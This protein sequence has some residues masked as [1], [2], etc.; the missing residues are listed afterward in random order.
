MGGASVRLPGKSGL[1]FDHI[2]ILK[3]ICRRSYGGVGRH[4]GVA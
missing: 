3:S 2:H 4:G 1:T